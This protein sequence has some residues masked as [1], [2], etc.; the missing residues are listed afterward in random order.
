VSGRQSGIRP[1]QRTTQSTFNVK[2]KTFNVKV[3]GSFTL[4][5]PKGRAR[6]KRIF[7]KNC[8]RFSCCEV[9]NQHSFSFRS[10]RLNLVL[11]LTSKGSSRVGRS[12]SHLS[13]FNVKCKTFNVK[14][15]SAWQGLFMRAITTDHRSRKIDFQPSTLNL[16]PSTYLPLLHNHHPLNRS[17]VVWSKALGFAIFAVRLHK[18][19]TKQNRNRFFA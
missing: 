17:W 8:H 7:V 18:K 14:C 6:A 15:K 10:Q 13:T 5:L 2:C 1:Y 4:R 3:I 19:P 12:R 9:S 11:V 16:E